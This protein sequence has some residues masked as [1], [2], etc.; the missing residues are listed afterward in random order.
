MIRVSVIMTAYNSEHCIAD[1]IQSILEQD[2]SGESYDLEL[3][4]V[5]DGSSDAT[6]EVVRSMGVNC[7]ELNANS[8]GPNKGRNIG[9]ERCTGDYICITDHDDIWSANRIISQLACVEQAPLVTCGY[10][11]IEE[12]TGK[13]YKRICGGSNGVHVFE[14]NKTF[15]DKLT[16]RRAGQS[17]NTYP[18]AI[19]FHKDLKTV[20]FEE[21]YGMVDYDWILRMFHNRNSVEVCD[22]LYTRIVTGDNLSLDEGYRHKDH[23]YSLE[24]VEQYA[25][26]Y[27]EEVQSARQR[28]NGSLARYYYL[29][30]NMPEA[31][32]YFRRSGW[33]WKTMAYYM[34]TYVGSALV[35]KKYKVF[36]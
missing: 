10:W 26:L 28:I 16:R 20:R 30:G 32:R 1:T 21:K 14:T 11:L 31:R 5:D 12:N 4:V 13:E 24:F 36:G 27:P 8:G 15:L 17:Q 18:G 35:R 23:A 7:I 19:M 29:V 33:T 34:T 6:V 9:L 3:V 2:G 25:G 22:A